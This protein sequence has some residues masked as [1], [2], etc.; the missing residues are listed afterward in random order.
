MHAEGING[1]T[2][3]KTKKKTV[4]KRERGRVSEQN[5]IASKDTARKKWLSEQIKTVSKDTA[6]KK[7][8]TAKASRSC[9]SDFARYSQRGPGSCIIQDGR[10]EYP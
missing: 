2:E 8:L 3:V 4:G 1:Q 6:P 7:W 5:K 10:F 9:K